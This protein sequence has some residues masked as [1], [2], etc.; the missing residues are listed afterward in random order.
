VNLRAAVAACALAGLAHAPARADVGDSDPAL[1]PWVRPPA[2]QP[3][4]GA[5]DPVA[6][7]RTLRPA[8]RLGPPP[9]RETDR[10]LL[11]ALRSQ[12]WAEALALAK[13][14]ASA[15]ARDQ[16]GGQPLVLAA[17]AGQ[18]EL[19]RLLL[20][21]GAEIDRTGEGGFTALGAAAFQGQ[22][23]TVRLLLRA[24]ASPAALGS[25][26]H[27]PLHLAAAAGQL[28]VVR[29]MLKQG[30]SLELLNR[31]RETALDVAAAADQQDVMVLLLDAGADATR[32]GRR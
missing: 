1:R 13:A 16:H 9:L 23:S 15:N 25:S 30:V 14:G 31:A 22:R 19:V 28:D 21:R 2:S 7:E 24:G 8:D 20:A 6:W 17:A 29:E 5:P 3:R 11:A 18:D 10:A 12:R 4:A 26:G 32:A 27:A